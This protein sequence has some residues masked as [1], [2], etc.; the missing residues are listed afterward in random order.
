MNSS[1]KFIAVFG[2]VS[3]VGLS[4]AA[5]LIFLV[6]PFFHYHMPW[7]GMEPVVNNEI[8]QNPGLADHAFYNSIIIGSSM[9]ENFDAEWFD[10]AYDIR[11]L[12]LNY[13]GASVEN[14]KVAVERAQ[15]SLNGEVQYVFGCID[16]E[17]LTNDFE[18]TRY[19][20]PEY[21]YDDVLYND[22][23]YLLNK[24]VLFQE[25]WN[26]WKANQDENVD[27]LNKA[28]M[29]YEKHKNDF[30]KENVLQG[31]DLPEEFFPIEQQNVSI[32]K[33]IIHAVQKIKEFVT[34]YPD[35]QFLF[36]YSPY[37]MAYWYSSYQSGR[38]LTDVS[39]LEYSMREL[40]NCENIKLYFPTSYEMITD[41]DSYKDT[42]H[43][44]MEIQY[45]IFEEMRDGDNY[46]TKDNYQEYI[47]EFRAMV[48][49]CDFSEIFR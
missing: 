14:L 25:T 6:D 49:D 41:L 1:K 48:M 9:T 2:L 20:L 7:F 10:E 31:L 38:F 29:W 17:I 4:M 45:Q 39:I 43:Y 8:Y 18:E 26:A 34:D 46:L 27:P 22:V 19:P 21:L 5:L 23:Y 30:S 36:F 28:Y 40:L 32:N 33:E 47:E 3:G 24:D 42:G 15:D 35:T 37:S 11:T 16:I 44:N 12:K 13:S